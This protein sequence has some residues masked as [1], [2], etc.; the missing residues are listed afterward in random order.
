MSTAIY[1]KA[2]LSRLLPGFRNFSAS[3]LRASTWK[4]RDLDVPGYQRVVT[5]D[6]PSGLKAIVAIHTTNLGPALGGLRIFPYATFDAALT[7]VTRL[8]R[9]MS[10]KSA[11][12]G[13]GLGGGKSVMLSDPQKVTEEMLQVYAAF[14]DT[15]GGKYI[16]AEDVGSTVEKIDYIGRYTPYVTG[17]SH[18]KSSGNPSPFTAWGV[19]R[20]IQATCQVLNGSDSVE[21]KT[22]AI[23]GLGSVGASLAE[24]LF[25]QGAR[26]VVADIDPARTAAIVRKYSAISCSP[27]EIHR[28]ECDILAPC[29]LGGTINS[30]TIPELQ[31]K[32]V[33]GCANNQLLE[34]SDA[35]ALQKRDILYAPDF[36]INAGG[37]INI[38]FELDA[39]GYRS[40]DARNAVDRIYRTVKEIFVTSKKR[41]MT[42]HEAAVSLAEVRIQKGIGQRK[43]SPRFHHFEDRIKDTL[44]CP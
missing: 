14:L 24:L 26:L 8:A 1:S 12:A 3:A 40:S 13:I 9:G 18:A 43:E 17:L 23:Q 42:T 6:D 28:Q 37:I 44:S 11:L 2:C 32:A 27:E 34:A 16:A 36:A 7:D 25:W 38:S 15:L 35:V 22:V 20:G 41:G 29:A 30:E 5:V 21:G 39:E 19:Y 31:C 4:I 10:H 33:A